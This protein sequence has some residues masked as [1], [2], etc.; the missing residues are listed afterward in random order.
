MLVCRTSSMELERLLML[1]YDEHLLVQQEHLQ[2][3]L[4]VQVRGSPN[5][6]ASSRE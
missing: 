2:V 6:I 5:F 4:Q 3:Q 1:E